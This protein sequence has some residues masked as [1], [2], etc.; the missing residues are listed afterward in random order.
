MQNMFR[1]M[2]RG[3]LKGMG[4]G[5]TSKRPPSQ[6]WYDARQM[7][8]GTAMSGHINRPEPPEGGYWPQ[9]R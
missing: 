5:A 8:Y 4:M 6:G 9:V 1:Q 2:A 7:L 3:G